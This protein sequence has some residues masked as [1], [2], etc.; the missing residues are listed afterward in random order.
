MA[1]T[2]VQEAMTEADR[3]S[4]VAPEK[5]RTAVERGE[6]EEPYFFFLVFRSIRVT[7]ERIAYRYA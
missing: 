2:Q 1:S 7:A 3:S 5:K 4:D 6:I